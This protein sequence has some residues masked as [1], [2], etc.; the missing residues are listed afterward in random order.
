MESWQT[1]ILLIAAAQGIFLSV[2]MLLPNK[3]HGSRVFLGIMLLVLSLEVLNVWG[4]QVGYHHAPGLIPFWLLGSY[5]LI[6]PSCWLFTLSNTVTGFT[7]R[8]KHALWYLPA[9]IEIITESITWGYNRYSVAP[10]SLLNIKAWWLATEI[11][12]ALWMLL[13]MIAGARRLVA[14]ARQPSGTAAFTGLH[15][16]RLLS[17]FI[18]LALLT[19]LWVADAVLLLPVF[20]AIELVL[21]LVLF[22]LSF[23]SYARL[24]FFEVAPTIKA[25]PAV[26]SKLPLPPVFAAWNDQQE[27]IR[28]QGVFE[29][30]GLH[31]R[32]KLSL[33]ELAGELNLPGR[34]VS[35]LINTYHAANFHHYINGWRVQEVIRKINDPAERH[36]TLLALALEAGFSSKSSFNQVF[37]DHTGKSP[38]QY[39]RQ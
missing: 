10:I 20:T 17:I 21:V 22:T 27:L 29:Q 14:C 8:K 26:K 4:M 38:S 33:D 34:Y 9:A 5:L 15:P 30:G 7:F 37:K 25:A 11:V 32:S 24:P 31:K 35:Y 39:F 19:V 16:A 1:G 2:A 18:L 23:L 13:V 28:L 36:K 12:P 3:K 6:P